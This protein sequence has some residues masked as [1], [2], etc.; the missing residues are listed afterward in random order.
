MFTHDCNGVLSALGTQTVL[1]L[2]WPGVVSTSQ[3]S[4]TDS[5]TAATQALFMLQEDDLCCR[6]GPRMH[7]VTVLI[8]KM[9]NIWSRHLADS[10]EPVESTTSAMR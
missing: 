5:S 7:I 8:T 4:R 1:G 2:G 10:K 3:I 6:I 9:N